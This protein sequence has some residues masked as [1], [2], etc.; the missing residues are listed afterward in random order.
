[1][2]PRRLVLVADDD[3]ALRRLVA[4]QLLQ[5]LDCE[6]LEA[7]DGDEAMRLALERQP[8]L[9]IVDVIMPGASGYDVTREVRRLLPGHLRVLIMS[10]SALSGDMADAFEAG[11]NAYLKKPFSGEELRE[12]VESLIDVAPSAD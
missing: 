8:D 5:F 2:Q 10:G 12:G 9:L 11:A 1:M 4:L 7:Q 3:A 6:V